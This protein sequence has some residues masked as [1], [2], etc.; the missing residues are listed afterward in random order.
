MRR[1]ELSD[2]QWELVDPL[3][4]SSRP[5]KSKTGRPPRD[6]RVMLNG[7]FWVLATGAPWRDMPERFGR[8]QSVYGRF[9][10]WRKAGVFAKIID[11]LQIKLDERGLINWELWCV[12]GANVRTSRAAAGADKRASSG[13]PT[14]PR[15]TPPGGGPLA[16]RVWIEVPRG[17]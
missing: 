2:E 13:T 6:P 7:D 15:T 17:H 1:H 5:R 12:G 3:L 8:W 14:S 11:A 4:R 16:R 9:F 10:R